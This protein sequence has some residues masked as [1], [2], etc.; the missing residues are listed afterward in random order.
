MS[1]KI[2]ILKKGSDE[3][4][5]PLTKERLIV[6]RDAACD[7]ALDDASISRR[8][9]NVIHKFGAIYIEN[10]SSTG[11]ILKSGQP[12]EYTQ[13]EEKEVVGIG[14]Y[15]LSWELDAEAVIEKAVVQ[16]VPRE[17]ESSEQNDVSSVESEED[18][19]DLAPIEAEGPE[20]AAQVSA[21]ESTRVVQSKLVGRLK[22]VKGEVVGREIKLEHGTSWTVG[23]ADSCQIP[24][25][26][27][28]MSRQHFRIVRSG[29]QYRLQDLESSAGLR[30]NGV[31]VSDAVLNPF[32]VIQAG[33]V[34]LQFL[35]VDAHVQHVES[36]PMLA[37]GSGESPVQGAELVA[38][39]GFEE[40][41]QQVLEATKIAMPPS[42][43]Y[44]LSQYSGAPGAEIPQFTNP[45]VGIG[46]SVAAAEEV[47]LSPLQRKIR[48]ATD[49][50]RA[51]PPAKQRVYA[52][53]GVALIVMAV[54][55]SGSDEQAVIT[56]PP[57]IRQ[58][59]SSNEPNAADP[60]EVSPEFNAFPQEKKEQIRTWHA[61]AER[62][63]NDGE[64]SKAVDI[65]KKI[66]AEVKRYKDVAEILQKAQTNL[67][68]E[69]IGTVTQAALS[70]S[71]AKSD[72]AS[73]VKLYIE[74]GRKKLSESK[75]SDAQDLFMR[76]LTLDPNNELA[77]KGY[78]AAAA[79]KT[80]LDDIELP[81]EAKIT[82][83]S[84]A[85]A[86]KKKQEEEKAIQ[87]E[88]EYLAGLKTQLNEGQ[89]KINSGVPGQSLS[90]LSNL[91]EKLSVTYAEYAEGG[92][93]PAS[94]KTEMIQEV[95]ALQSLTN[96]AEYKALAMLKSEYQI[97]FADAEQFV[98]N[99][100]YAEAR[101]VYDKILEKEP[102]FEEAMKLRAAL[103]D[104]LVVEAKVL[105]QEALI[106]ESLS[107]LE[108]ARGGYSKTVELLTN[109]DNQM[110]E[111]Y[112]RKADAK[113]KRLGGK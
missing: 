1:R 43:D 18:R 93:A 15:Q 85:E 9:A 46:V 98:Q 25:D 61:Q 107:D 73:K 79:Q 70:A 54:V 102:Y 12:T 24:I 21:E 89:E 40:E 97:Q 92:R 112:Y 8:H 4:R 96:E 36:L 95:Q 105:Y 91:K 52:G 14:S 100:Q 104:K 17:P 35:M 80:S 45:G 53:L 27:A 99:K 86:E 37:D 31:T 108:N 94:A 84:L 111:T 11:Q 69:H 81:P 72:N 32:D 67:N 75:W 57:Q 50:Y 103:Y 76:A 26:N 113:L 51:L 82:D 39:G 13:L 83:A 60:R 30:I 42:N 55:G 74:D 23:R 10:I 44:P 34:D 7:V 59:A 106:Y 87:N 56:E 29:N 20:D 48:S 58:P 28:K 38:R 49:W 90:I 71:D 110:A 5:I 16:E 88:R 65:S 6:G 62:A 63:L 109:V 77:V 41:G 101:Q 33:P 3:K 66:L 2:L 68:E 19:R 47:R 64:W 22:V 78:G